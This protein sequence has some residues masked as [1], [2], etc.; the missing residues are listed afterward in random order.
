MSHGAPTFTTYVVEGS[1]ITITDAEGDV[2][3][4]TFCQRGDELVMA[5]EGGGR[6]TF[7]RQ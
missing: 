5:S 4:G 1:S 6:S 2:D 7:R 3:V